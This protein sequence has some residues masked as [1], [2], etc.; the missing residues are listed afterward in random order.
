ML[1]SLALSEYEGVDF[2][3]A[4]AYIQNAGGIDQVLTC[5]LFNKSYGETDQLKLCEDKPQVVPAK[6]GKKQKKTP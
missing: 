6:K 4:K 5:D 2:S 1:L 3:K